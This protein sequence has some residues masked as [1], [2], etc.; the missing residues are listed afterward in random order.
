MVIEVLIAKRDRKH[1]LPHQRDNLMLDKFGVAPIAK[2]P[3]EASNQVNGAIG[4]PEKQG[5]CLR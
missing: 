5:S 2:A 1:A 4:R 3:S